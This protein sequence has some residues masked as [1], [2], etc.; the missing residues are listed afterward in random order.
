MALHPGWCVVRIVLGL[1]LVFTSVSFASVNERLA[2]RSPEDIMK[3]YMF[4][5]D[6]TT[7]PA[8]R[9]NS[10]EVFWRYPITLTPP[11][12]KLAVIEPGDKLELSREFPA[13]PGSGLAVHHLN[14]G[15][16]FF[17]KQEW[18][19]ACST[20]LGA[21]S[22]YG[23]DF[24]YHRRNDLFIAN[25][26]LYR[27]HAL[28]QNKLSKAQ[29]ADL[30]VFF[31][32]ANTFFS[33]AL[34]VKK[35][36]NDP[37]IDLV[38]PR[39]FYNQAV[40][41][42]NYEKWP[43]AYGAVTSG[44]N[45][46]RKTGR[47]EFLGS[48]RRILAELYIKNRSYLEAIQEFDLALRTD[49]LVENGALIFARAADIYFD[50][51][52]FELAE[53]LYHLAIQ[54]DQSLNQHRPELYILRGESLFWLGRFA[55]AQKMMN[56][57]LRSMSLISNP[58]KYSSNDNLPALASMRIADAWLAQGKYDKAKLAYFRHVQNFRNH[59]TY[60]YAQLR[61]A[62]LELPSYQ[63][64]NV[65][66][67]RKLLAEL[68]SEGEALPPYAQ[69]LAWTCEMAS[70]AQHERSQKM[71]QRAK[72]FAEKYPD[73]P[74]ISD[75][76]PA[77]KDTQD[78]KL[79]DLL[80]EG[81]VYESLSFYEATKDLLYPNPSPALKS[82]LFELYVLTNQSD[83]ASKFFLEKPFPEMSPKEIL[84]RTTNLVE[85]D[86][87]R[88]NAWTKKS[89]DL[90][91]YL[92]SNPLKIPATELFEGLIGRILSQP[93]SNKAHLKWIWP[94][95]VSWSKDD[96][97]KACDYLFPT[98]QQ[99]LSGS[100]F[101][102]SNSNQ[103]LKDSFNNYLRDNLND[104]IRFQTN[105]SYS[106]LEL[107]RE[108]FSSN[109]NELAELY[110]ARQFMPINSNTAS[111]F[112]NLAED[113]LSQGY[114]ELAESLWQVILQKGNQDLPEYRFAQ[115]RLSK[116]RTELEDLWE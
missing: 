40:I 41:Y 63:G 75:I 79:F 77:V 92:I 29:K 110:L 20:W 26:F 21:R 55:E 64:N 27:A 93:N 2:N 48:M 106:Y 53:D 67:A 37:L 78:D 108:L 32:N 12:F 65:G 58:K 44:L 7:K 11:S 10:K 82:K 14:R 99:L 66:H 105:C 114:Q 50:L 60:R 113:N 70:Y 42:Y 83:K 112:H 15:R 34:N 85:M 100:D 47:K 28:S 71:I 33:W 98:F 88:G 96:L 51:N 18:Q 87:M 109:S 74:L 86:A 90:A 101:A 97:K 68:K 4:I 45:F 111:L 73:S 81:K 38:T 49:P 5:G 24:P 30:R 57:G 56:Y 39:S 16:F 91:D 115:S 13:T 36:L 54:L 76:I 84:I 69:E 89:K 17:L 31:V 95:M 52:N 23:N 35:D 8:V 62:C 6:F 104:L 116:D 80:K 22:R 103:S 1:S 46:L 102:K 9:K 3:N 25:C 19:K 107:E 61:S 59:E 72:V 43:G 94:A